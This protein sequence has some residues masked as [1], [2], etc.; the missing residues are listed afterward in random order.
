MSP[1]THEGCHAELITVIPVLYLPGQLV[2]DRR[3]L[4]NT[5]S[6]LRV[7]ECCP[8]VSGPTTCWAFVGHW[9]SLGLALA[10]EDATGLGCVVIT[11]LTSRHA[12]TRVSL[13][14]AKPREAKLQKR[15]KCGRRVPEIEDESER[16]L[17]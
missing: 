16:V 17:E 7:G 15:R 1:F 12:G 2:T 13:C 4:V 5:D 6:C 3:G 14:P 9:E 11:S 10:K 8:A